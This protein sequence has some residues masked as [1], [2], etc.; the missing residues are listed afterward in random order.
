MALIVAHPTQ[1]PA[2]L[3]AADARGT[4]L[5]RLE[6]ALMGIDH[7]EAG[8]WFAQQLQLPQVFQDVAGHHHDADAVGPTD[9]LVRV[10]VACQLADWMG[11]WVTPLPGQADQDATELDRASLSL[12][13]AQRMVLLGQIDHLVADVGEQVRATESMFEA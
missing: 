5:L 2:L 3:D 1:Y 11:Y 4:D 9:T 12:P 8:Q 7:C 10:S 13:L 6:R